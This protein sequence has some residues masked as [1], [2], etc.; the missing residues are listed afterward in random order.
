[1]RLLVVVLLCVLT[2][3]QQSDAFSHGNNTTWN[4]SLL[5]GGWVCF[6]AQITGCSQGFNAACDGLTDDKVAWNNFLTYA[7]GVSMAKLY[8]PPGANCVN[9][10][11]FKTTISGANIHVDGTKVPGLIIWA[12]GAAFD[13]IFLGTTGAVFPDNTH[14]ALLQNARASDGTITL[15]NAGD[16]SIF[17]VGKWIIVSGLSTQTYGYPPNWFV[18]EYRKITAI[19]GAVLTLNQPLSYSYK[20]TWP[21]WDAGD[22]NNVNLGGPA[23]AF[24]LN[25]AWDQDL[26]I[27]GLRIKQTANDVYSSARSITLNYMV[28]DSVG[29]APSV[30]MNYTVTNSFVGTPEFDKLVDTL[31]MDHVSARQF[32]FQSAS[33]NHVTI[34]NVT[35]SS[36]MN[37]TPNNV[38]ISKSTMPRMFV[39]PLG[40]GHGTSISIADSTVAT[41]SGSNIC[42][43]S[44]AAGTTAL[45]Y[46]SGRFTLPK[47]A[48][49]AQKDDL[50][51]WAIPGQ[52]YYFGDIDATNN[53]IPATT[54]TITDFSEDASN[55]YM[56]TD[57]VGALPTP[58][59]SFIPCRCYTS[60]QA[61]SVTQTNS[62]PADLTQFAAP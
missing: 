19:N 48:P 4:G 31:T 50:F 6:Q 2:L 58:T 60:W 59:C 14:S 32:V 34:S 18:F 22:A 1:M 15:K 29:V 5:G 28:F 17:S 51:R 54:F 40:F 52:K 26:T 7:S 27:Y 55:Y 30:S 57:M 56:D 39:G 37:G 10:D 11:G 16:V 43:P 49:V 33:F 24:V 44:V 45:S 41:A 38:S 9:S 62:G 47:T 46:S 23:T 20:S 3:P 8:I 13:S 36:V 42:L 61:S 12:H 25:D 53:S 21:Q 35:L